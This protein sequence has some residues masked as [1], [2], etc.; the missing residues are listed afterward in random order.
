MLFPH[1]VSYDSQVDSIAHNKLMFLGLKSC[2]GIIFV[3]KFVRLD[4]L[5]FK[6][7]VLKSEEGESYRYRKEPKKSCD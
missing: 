3:D 2:S 7:F 4:I 6:L 1:H 5:V